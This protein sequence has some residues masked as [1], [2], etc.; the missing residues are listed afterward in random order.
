MVVA[1]ALLAACA[2]QVAPLGGEKD[3]KPP[4]VLHTQPENFSTDFHSKKIEITFD[5]YVQLKDLSSQLIV[6][7]PLKKIPEIKIKKK[8]L[9]IEIDDTLRT[10]TTYTMNFGNAILDNN[11]GNPLE[12]Y[13]YVFS[14]GNRLDSLKVS[15]KVENAIDK[16]TEKGILVMLYSE[17][18]DSLPLNSRPDYFAKTNDHG[19][20][21]VTNIAPGNYRMF[22]LKESNADYL[23]NTPDEN[24]AFSDSGV[25]AG[26]KDHVMEL[27]RERPRIHVLKSYSEEPGKA[28]VVMNGPAEETGVRL[29]TD[30]TKCDFVF[31]EK[32]RKRDTV[33]CWYKNLN[34]DSLVLL[35]TN[36]SALNDTVSIRL[37]KGDGKLFSKRKITLGFT[38]NFKPGDFFDLNRD[39]I[40][41]LNHPVTAFD[42]SKMILSED[43][44][45]IRPL[46]VAFTDSTKRNLDIKY[47]WK[48]KSTYRI[49]IPPGTFTDIFGLKNDTFIVTCRTRQV[50]DYGTLALKMKLPVKSRHYIVQ[51]VD[52]KENVYRSSVIAS[53]TTLNYDFLDPKVYRVKIIEDLNRN[54]EWDTGNY[55]RKEQPERVSYYPEGITIRS[56]WDVDVSWSPWK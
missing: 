23:Y 18:N 8:S 19:V 5:E 37:F 3:T 27:F 34:L 12:N 21:Q 49:F 2:N 13:Q 28:V 55:F 24:I 31:F 33:I 51:L 7:P 17:E 48:E 56:N 47:G 14:T 53:D 11:E 29:L 43:S 10:N 4:K 15:G 30:S 39:M 26:S 50:T 52:D 22:A 36:A 41:L 45:N 20:F 44:V 35:F 38:P 6:S 54:G 1:F 9:V 40:L 46:S 32:S 42:F 16:K 25:A